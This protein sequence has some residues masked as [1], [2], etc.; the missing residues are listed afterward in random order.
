MLFF[1]QSIFSL[2][3]VLYVILTAAA[4]TSDLVTNHNDTSP[5]IPFRLSSKANVG[6]PTADGTLL[7]PSDNKVD[8]ANSNSTNY[9]F[10]IPVPHTRL[11]LQLADFGQ[12]MSSASVQGLYAYALHDLQSKI[13]SGQAE[14]V[15]PGF[16]YEYTSPQH[17]LLSPARI[18][19]TQGIWRQR[20]TFRDL[21]L[22]VMRLRQ[23]TTQPGILPLEVLNRGFVYQLY[24]EQNEQVFSLKV[25][26]G[27]VDRDGRIHA[28]NR[29]VSG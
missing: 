26:A 21:V 4:P 10:V 22:V 20:G 24:L 28:G 25:G 16:A 13:N 7:E 15:P 29:T 11:W 23:V 2:F 17:P 14:Q 19:W 1:D 8:V 18:T 9:Y 6:C 27:V 3:Y 5:G 12:C